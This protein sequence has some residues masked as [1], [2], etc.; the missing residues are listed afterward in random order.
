MASCRL[1][2]HRPFGALAARNRIGGQNFAARQPC[3][4]RPAARAFWR[5]WPINTVHVGNRSRWGAFACGCGSHRPGLGAAAVLRQPVSVR[6]AVDQE[7][8]Q[9]ARRSRFGCGC[10]AVRIR[11]R[12]ALPRP[13]LGASATLHAG[14]PTSVRLRMRCGAHRLNV[15]NRSRWGAFAFGLRFASARSRCGCGA[16]ATGLGAVRIR[17]RCLGSH[18]LAVRPGLG[19]FSYRIG[20]KI[21]AA[22]QLCNVQPAA[23]AFWR[24]WPIN[25]VHVGRSRCTGLGALPRQPVLLRSGSHSATCRATSA[26]S[27]CIGNVARWATDLGA[28]AVRF[29]S[30]ER[31]QPVSL[32]SV[33]VRLAVRIGQV[34]VRLRCYGNRSRCGSHPVS[35]PRFA[36]ASGSA[37]PRCVQ[38]PDRGEIFAAGQLCNVQ[39]AA[40]AFLRNWPINTVHVGN[41]SR[42][43]TSATGL[44]A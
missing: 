17:S 5:N 30:V 31:R 20:G 26:R 3:N 14:Q 36:S 10:V 29:A 21:F 11:Q 24:N 32:G 15:G 12:A 16:T 39:P 1:A 13:G 43:T 2:G 4:V 8:R 6:F 27:R 44:A 22:G 34:S 23:R 42:C 33:R 18:R 37:R 35:L 38:L 25:T 9:A 28:D 19:A 40:R 41:W 7:R